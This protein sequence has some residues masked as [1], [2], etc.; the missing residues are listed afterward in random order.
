MYTGCF[1][2]D[3]STFFYNEYLA[4]NIL[5]KREFKTLYTKKNIFDS[6]VLR[7]QEVYISSTNLSDKY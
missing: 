6:K 5:I 7:A 4:C 2:P 3:C 1:L